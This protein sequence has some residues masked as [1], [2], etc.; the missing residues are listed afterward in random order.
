MESAGVHAVSRRLTVAARSL[1]IPLAL[2]TYGCHVGPTDPALGDDD[3]EPGP[4][5]SSASP[6]GDD[7]GETPSGD[8]TAINTGV[9]ETGNHP[10]GYEFQMDSGQ[11]CINAT[12]HTN[13]QGPSWKVA[14]SLYTKRDGPGEPI[15]GAHIFLTDRD[16]TEVHLTTAMN[17]FFYTEEDVRQPFTTFASG[18]PNELPMVAPSTSGNCN[19]AN[20]HV[21]TYKIY[22][23]DAP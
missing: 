11:G 15:A 3:D 19:S 18:C 20:C 5:S 10:E 8:C 16:G 4:D 12:C 21:Q 23:S 2:V 14:G 22:L 17:G 7:A 13:N 9:T 1:L 6:G